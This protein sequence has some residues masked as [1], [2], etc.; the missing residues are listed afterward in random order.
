MYHFGTAMHQLLLHAAID[1]YTAMSRLRQLHVSHMSDW[2]DSLR[3]QKQAQERSHCSYTRS[4]PFSRVGS[5]NNT[6]S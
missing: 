2:Y 6:S 5:G 4:L 1:G 3:I